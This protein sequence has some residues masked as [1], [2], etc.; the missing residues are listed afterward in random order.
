MYMHCTM[1]P[2]V[3][4]AQR[5]K[6]KAS[7]SKA[8]HELVKQ[9]GRALQQQASCDTHNP[10]HHPRGHGSVCTAGSHYAASKGVKCAHP[11]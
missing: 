9:A 11:S 7:G 5:C 4:T 6:V 1:Q 3:L 10:H 2:F 8:A